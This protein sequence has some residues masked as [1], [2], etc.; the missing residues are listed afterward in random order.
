MIKTYIYHGEDDTRIEDD[1]RENVI[2]L[3]KL[4]PKSLEANKLIVKKHSIRIGDTIV[5]HSK[6]KNFL[7]IVRDTII[8]PGIKDGIC[9]LME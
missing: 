2:T 1:D 3:T 4:N 9:E 5:Q 6:A 7:D 8:K